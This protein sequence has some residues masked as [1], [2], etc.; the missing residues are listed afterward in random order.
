MSEGSE[1]VDIVYRN[2]GVGFI[3]KVGYNEGRLYTKKGDVN[4]TGGT[5]KFYTKE[6]DV[7]I[8]RNGGYVTL[9]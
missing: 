4:P 9:G 7:V 8:E 6:R 1:K 5:L 2:G 3:E